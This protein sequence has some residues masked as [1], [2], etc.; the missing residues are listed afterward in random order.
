MDSLELG[1]YHRTEDLNVQMGL[2]DTLSGY[3]KLILSAG[4]DVLF[5]CNKLWLFRMPNGVH[6]VRSTLK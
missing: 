5:M 4:L 1:F 2:S 6:F 3:A